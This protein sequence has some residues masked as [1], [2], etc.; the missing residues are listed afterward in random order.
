VTNDSYS[1][2]NT[3]AD[4]IA[5]SW[6]SRTYGREWNGGGVEKM[7]R[8]RKNDLEWFDLH[9]VAT[10]FT[11]K[12]TYVFINAKLFSNS[13]N[14]KKCNVVLHLECFVTFHHM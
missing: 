9:S 6:I 3:A 12:I 5:A 13:H 1:S 8:G 10:Y 4:A 11:K 2:E 7:R 14:C